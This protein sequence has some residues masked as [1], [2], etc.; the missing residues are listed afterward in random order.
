MSKYYH[1]CVT[2]LLRDLKILLIK[3][4]QTCDQLEWDLAAKC[5]NYQQL[6]IMKKNQVTFM[7]YSF[8]PL[9][10]SDVFTLVFIVCHVYRRISAIK[11]VDNLPSGCTHDL[12]W[13]II[14][15]KEIVN[16]WSQY[17]RE[18][19]RVFR[20][21]PA[22]LGWLPA[23]DSSGDYKKTF[24]N[25]LFSFES[26]RNFECQLLHF[27]YFQLSGW[28]VNCKHEYSFWIVLT[29]IIHGIF[30]IQHVDY[31]RWQNPPSHGGNIC[32]SMDCRT[33]KWNF[34]ICVVGRCL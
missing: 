31:L 3:W 9:I 13:K 7:I 33:W 1:C 20:M 2:I 29:S 12:S 24:I 26:R 27:N 23:S 16:K 30:M 34:Y 19:S 10:Y 28:S 14:Q 17:F 25:L 21:P 4:F 5:S 11:S 6:L 32:T 18:T 22:V 15:L 8:F